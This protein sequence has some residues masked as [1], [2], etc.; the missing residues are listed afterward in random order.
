MIGCC[1]SIKH[2][3]IHI[4]D[5]GALVFYAETDR[6]RLS[7]TPICYHKQ[8]SFIYQRH[9]R[10]DVCTDTQNVFKHYYAGLLWSLAV[11]GV[12]KFANFIN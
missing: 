10:D 7:C 5:H 11:M 8:K 12:K 9:L 3:N 2:L 4:L 1:K 6:S